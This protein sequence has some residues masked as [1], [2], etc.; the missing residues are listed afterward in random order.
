[1]VPVILGQSTY[2]SEGQKYSIRKI[3]LTL[4]SGFHPVP[5]RVQ[6]MQVVYLP[7]WKI[8]K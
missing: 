1:M 2:S 7:F 4:L 3:A 6:L 8:K 5:R